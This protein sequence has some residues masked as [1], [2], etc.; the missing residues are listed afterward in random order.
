MMEF[1]VNYWPLVLVCI[2]L[3]MLKFYD[4]VFRKR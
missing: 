3:L 2:T 1:L 4:D